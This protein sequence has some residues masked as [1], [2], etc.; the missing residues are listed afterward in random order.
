MSEIT[1]TARRVSKESLHERIAL[2]GPDDEL[3]QLADT[4]DS[5]LA[6]LEAGFEREKGYVPAPPTS[7]APRFQRD[8][9]RGRRHPG[10]RGPRPR[11]W[12]T[13]AGR[14]ARGGRAQRAADRRA[15]ALAL[16]DHDDQPR[17]EVELSGLA[18]QLTDEADLAGPRL[19]LFRRLGRARTGDG[20]SLACRSPPRSRRPT[21]GS[22]RSTRSSEAGCRSRSASG[23]AREPRPLGQR[24]P[25]LSRR[26]RPSDR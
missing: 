15:P 12:A 18:R 6:R 8:T 7:C 24:S 17:V 25:A 1:A 20:L 4:F 26:W 14:G 5:M 10:R 2:E 21:G 11:R 19:E 22:S 3:K 9:R 23:S 16:A 13:L